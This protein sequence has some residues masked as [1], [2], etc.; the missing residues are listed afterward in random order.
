MA[1]LSEQAFCVQ[2]SVHASL[3]L[4]AWAWGHF[5]VTANAKLVEASHVI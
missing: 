1:L 2:E 4:C 5:I 3:M